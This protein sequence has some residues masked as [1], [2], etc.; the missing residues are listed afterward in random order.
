MIGSYDDL[1][2][3]YIPSMLNTINGND[4]LPSGR[5]RQPVCTW[6]RMELC[7]LGRGI[8]HWRM[9]WGVEQGGF[10]GDAVLHWRCACGCKRLGVESRID[11]FFL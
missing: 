10:R 6:R 4:L 3:T 11:F 8:A 1:V 2:D 9:L 5:S 7:E